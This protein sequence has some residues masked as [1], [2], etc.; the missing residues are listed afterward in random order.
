MGGQQGWWRQGRA[1][2]SRGRQ[3]EIGEGKERQGMVSL[4]WHE[5]VKSKGK[6]KGRVT[7]VTEK[8]RA[9]NGWSSGD[10]G[11]REERQG[12][13]DVKS[14]RWE[15][16]RGRKG[17]GSNGWGDCKGWGR[18]RGREVMGRKIRDGKYKGRRTRREGRKGKEEI[19]K[20]R[21]ERQRE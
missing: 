14:K 20:G 8:G 7:R 21:R 4:W 9:R 18:D 3:G 2:R 5:A 13:V 11:R 17:E 10:E 19:G 16:V 15:G 6:G 1:R 12:M